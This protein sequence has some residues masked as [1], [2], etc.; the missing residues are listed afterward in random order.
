MASNSQTRPPT[1]YVGITDEDWYKSLRGLAQLDE[2]NFWQPSSGGGFQAIQP[3]EPFLFK[4]HQRYGGRIVGCAFFADYSTAPISWAWEAF[5]IKNGVDSLATMRR[6]VEHYRSATTPGGDHTVGCI[7][8]QQ[9]VFFEVQD[10]LPAPDWKGPIQRG[11]RYRLD[12]EPGLTLWREVQDR[13]RVASHPERPFDL[14]LAETPARYGAPA[15]AAPRLGQGSFQLAVLGAYG[16][17]CAIT[18][19]RVLPTLEAAHIKPYA[20]GGEH[21]TDNGLLLR[22]DVHS[23]F[24]RGYMAITPEHEIVVSQRLHTEFDN[25]ADYLSLNG[26]RMQLPERPQ[27]RPRP[28]FLEWHLAHKYVA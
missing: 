25:G 5:G 16:R 21:R 11:R 4:Q 20:E 1:A 18:G 6:R 3:G 7:L 28:D 22:R 27:H 8:L 19:E 26:T 13:I 10:G 2:V 23:L 17:R 15:F 24:D 12:E 14:G 9:P